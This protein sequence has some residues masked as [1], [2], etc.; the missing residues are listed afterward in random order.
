MTMKTHQIISIIG[1][2]AAA[3]WFTICDHFFHVKN[4][5]LIYHWMPLY[6]NQS[7]WAFPIFLCVTT[8]FFFVTRQ[9]SSSWK[10]TPS[11]P[12][13][14]ANVAFLTLGYLASGIAG[15]S[16]PMTFF[17]I[18]LALWGVRILLVREHRATAIKACL[19]LGIIGPA[20]EG[21]TS[22]LGYFNYHYVNI[23]NV[24][25]WLFALYLHA[26][27]LMLEL[28]SFRELLKRSGR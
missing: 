8:T 24:P 27:F 11:L 10:V 18:V 3:A 12:V 15:I 1:I 23:F 13:I 16:H 14:I 25:L 4:N 9:F 7:V 22:Q 19:M 21:A 2:I 17:W 26:G 6:D 5:I 20:W 28:H